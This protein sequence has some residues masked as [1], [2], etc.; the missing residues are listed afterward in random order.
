MS[1]DTGLEPLHGSC[2]CG[3]NRYLI[4]I[5]ED[6]TDHARIYFDTSSD[7]RNVAIETLWTFGCQL[8]SLLQLEYR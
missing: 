2:S 3:R 6:V 1:S 8:T 5:P 4:R 7:N